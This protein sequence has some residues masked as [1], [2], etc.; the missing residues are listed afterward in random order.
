[1]LYCVCDFN[2]KMVEGPAV[3]GYISILL[4]SVVVE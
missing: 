4:E 2:G 1:V 3:F